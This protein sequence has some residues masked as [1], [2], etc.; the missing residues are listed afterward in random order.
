[1]P[2]IKRYPN[3]KLYDTEAKR[4][5]TLEQV[6]QM[7]RDG[8]EV[9]V[10]D[11]KSGEDLTRLTLS[12][13]LLAQEKGPAGFLPIDVLTG[14]IRSGGNLFDF[15]LRTARG[16]AG[17]PIQTIEQELDQLVEAGTLSREQARTVVL[18]MTVSQTARAKPHLLDDG[19]AAILHRLNIP[20][21]R[22]IA[23]L[24]AKLITLSQQLNELLPEESDDKAA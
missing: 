24:R 3:R 18:R 19:V 12:Q 10:R 20:T 16:G 15:I 4:Y 6:A 2:L 17:I 23:A 8:Q 22:D 9:E 21:N 13:I 11:H 5:V 7:V 1:M 14:L